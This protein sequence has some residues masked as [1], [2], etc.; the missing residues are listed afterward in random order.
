MYPTPSCWR[1]SHVRWMCIIPSYDSHHLIVASNQ[2]RMYPN[3]QVLIPILGAK[4]HCHWWTCHDIRMV[5]VMYPSHQY[6]QV[7]INLKHGL[8]SLLFMYR[9]L[10]ILFSSHPAVSKMCN[11]WS[12]SP[13]HWR[14]SHRLG[15]P[16]QSGGTA[17]AAAPTVDYPRWAGKNR[18]FKHV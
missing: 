10:I 3:H 9:V 12:H 8:L 4:S 17:S 1:V 16:S 15:S 13:P 14:S 11:S 18:Q 7:W 5:I 2:L 6:H